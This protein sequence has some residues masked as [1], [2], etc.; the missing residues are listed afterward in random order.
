MKLY[1]NYLFLGGWFYY[2]VIPLVM[3]V[4]NMFYAYPGINH[5]YENY[6][7]NSI[8][9]YC[10]YIIFFLISFIL[11]SISPLQFAKKRRCLQRKE[12]VIGVRDL[13]YFFTFPLFLLGQYK[14]Y[15][16]RSILFQGYQV[17]Y[18]VGLMGTIAT[19]NV[20]FIFFTVY[21]LLKQKTSKWFNYFL[22]FSIVEFSIVLLGLGSRLYVLLPVVIFLLYA[23]DKKIITYKKVFYVGIIFIILFLSVGLW[24]LGNNLKLD[25]LMY[26]GAAESML[27]WISAETYFNNDLPLFAFPAHFLSSFINFIPSVVFPDKVDY[28]LPIDA[29]FYTPFGA[30]NIIVSLIYN[31][32]IIG[33]FLVIYFFG[34]FLTY[35]RL[36]GKSILFKSYYYCICG[37]IPFQ[38]F[39]DDIHVLTKMIFYNFL[40]LPLVF[41]L[42]EKFL[43]LELFKRNQVNKSRRF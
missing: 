36:N 22:F 27:T 11:G 38:L 20:I 30:L 18:D 43:C 26:I 1:H 25:M 24:R 13:F 14:I 16:N 6:D 35:V 17:D 34:F 37:V 32:G 42:F 2:L 8:F 28:I 3:V 9:K 31:F 12:S 10:L 7:E 39:R 15:Q 29:N 19:I 5:V 21:N 41:L 23:I 40:I 33:S 4:C